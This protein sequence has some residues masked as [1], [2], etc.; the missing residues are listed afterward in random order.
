MSKA[1]KEARL[2]AALRENLK[3]RKAGL[4][5]ADSRTSPVKAGT[6]RSSDVEDKK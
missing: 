2:A 4:A 6:Q 1:D 3:K 5:P